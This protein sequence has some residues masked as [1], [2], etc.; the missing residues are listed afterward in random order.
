MPLLSR[1][2]RRKAERDAAKRAGQGRSRGRRGSC[3]RS[4]K[5]KP[6]PG[7]RLDDA[8]D[9][10]SVL[11]HALG[12][13]SVKQMARGGER[14]AQWSQGNLLLGEAAIADAGMP[15]G[16]AG[17]SPMTDAELEELCK[18]RAE[19]EY[20]TGRSPKADVGL[21]LCTHRVRALTRLSALM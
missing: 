14:E 21:E 11:L 6:E 7:R 2:E 4:R 5:F 1:Q 13:R 19:V 3:R 16:A 17:R 12:A 15:L 8:L 18:M 10:P 20:Q 9:D